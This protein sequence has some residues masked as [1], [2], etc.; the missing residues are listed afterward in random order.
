[1]GYKNAPF[2]QKWYELLNYKF[3]PLKQHA[4]RL[5]K[6]LQLW[7][8]GHGKTTGII[9]YILWLIGNYPNIHIQIVS[10]TAS[11]AEQICT[12]IMTIIEQD[13]NYTRLFGNLK[14]DQPIKWTSQ[15]F[16]VNR[17]EISKNPTLKSSGLMG[18]ITGGRNDLIICDDIIDEENVRTHLQI[19]KANTWFNKILYPTLYPWGGIVVIGTRWSYADLYTELLDKWPHSVLKAISLDNKVLWPQY[20]PLPKLEERR[21]EI[22]TIIFNCQYQNDPSDMEGDLLKGEWLHPWD[23]PPNITCEYYAAIDPSLGEHDYFGIAIGAYDRRWNK[24]YLVDVITE[25][26]PLAHIIKDRI[27]QLHKYYKFQK[28]YFEKNFWQKLL[29]EVPELKA[30]PIVPIQTVRDKTSRF[31]SMTS[32]FEAKRILVNPA[33]LNRSE[34]YME[35]IQYPHGQHDDG[36]DAVEMLVSHMAKAQAAKPVFKLI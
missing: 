10:K 7:P 3:S 12:A 19:E 34:F 24:N 21:N 31:I 27:P 16:I 13:S 25:H 35:W 14:P 6:Y 8:R 26:Q 11:Q 15:Q 33:L 36:L 29:L 9:L 1:M 17:T 18:P 32:H 23:R 20:W 4:D 5:K 22:G 28:V 30:L 2:H